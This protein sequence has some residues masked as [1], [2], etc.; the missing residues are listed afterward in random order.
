MS[1]NNGLTKETDIRVKKFS[2]MMSGKPSNVLGK[3]WKLSEAD[4]KRKSE[5]NKRLGIKIPVWSVSRPGPQN[6]NWH[7]GIQDDPYSNKFKKSLKNRIKIRD[8]FTCQIC[9]K[10]LKDSLCVHHI[11]YDKQNCKEDN[12]ITLHSNCHRKTNFNRSY[13]INYFNLAQRDK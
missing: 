11:D 5:T 10:S 3:H 1:W 4:N 12:L 7:G 9:F 8:N 13:W 2:E 6:P